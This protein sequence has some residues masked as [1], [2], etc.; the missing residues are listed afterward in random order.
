MQ[1]PFLPRTQIWHP[2]PNWGT[3]RPANFLQ[4]MLKHGRSLRMQHLKTVEILCALSIVY[5]HVCWCLQAAQSQAAS[6]G[7]A[8]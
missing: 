7:S 1:P 8:H 3:D 6:T 4:L 5:N 2:S